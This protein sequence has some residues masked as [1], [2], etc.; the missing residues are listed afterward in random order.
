MKNH[1]S[2]TGEP[3]QVLADN[4]KKKQSLQL[5]FSLTWSTDRHSQNTASIWNGESLEHLTAY[6]LQWLKIR[7]ERCSFLKLS[8]WKIRDIQSI[9]GMKNTETRGD[10]WSRPIF[11]SLT[12]GG[13]TKQPLPSE[14]RKRSEYVFC[15]WGEVQYAIKAQGLR[16]NCACMMPN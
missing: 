9:Y 7:P 16:C 3:L 4:E 1:I 5:V 13:L 6:C 2:T 14:G 10:W 11:F 15:T 12:G 8:N